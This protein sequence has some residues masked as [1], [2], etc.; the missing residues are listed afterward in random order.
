MAGQLELARKAFEERSWR[1]AFSQLAAACTEEALGL[2]D[3][4]LLAQ[5]AYLCGEDAASEKAW[6]EANQRSAEKADWARAARCAFWLGVTLQAR[7]ERSQAG[8]WFA[9]AQRVL[10]DNDHDCVERG[11]LLVGAGLKLHHERNYDASTQA[12]EQALETGKHFND[13]DL[14]ATARQGLGRILIKQ[15]RISKGSPMLDESMVAVLANE[16]SPIP[17][18]II[19]CSVIEACQEILDIARA[20]EWTAALSDWLDAQ[21]DLVPYRG[22]CQI[23]RSEIMTLEGR[24]ADATEEIAEA[25]ERLV[26]PPQPQLGMALNQQAEVHR[27]RGE[28]DAAE[29]A[30][31]Q[32]NEKAFVL[33][34]G[35][36][37]LKLAKGETE[38]AVAAIQ[39]SY[40]ATSKEVTRCRVLPAYVEI[41]LAAG[42]IEAAKAGQEELAEIA[43]TLDSPFLRGVALRCKGV[44]LLAQGN[45]ADALATF[46]KVWEHWSALEV[47]YE[48]AR[49]R[50]LNAQAS[51]QAGDEHTANSELDAARHVFEQLGA[52]HDLKMLEALSGSTPAQTPGGL[53]PREVQI[54]SL[55]AKGRSN[56]EIASELVISERT[57]A[58]HMSNIFN[59]LDVTSRTAASAF[60]FENNLV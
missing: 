24:W 9:R 26:K 32:A 53:S 40:E 12:W 16:V 30:Y 59:K 25:C 5:T 38:A 19:Y 2:D 58:R 11:W 31:R 41:K 43:E 45:A 23:H 27:L 29:E 28:F 35:W 22:R 8:G 18:G 60:A 15:G 57:V 36:A 6:I 51:K 4:E 3:L 42:N 20:Q 34:P 52:A 33:Q 13:V 10:E 47:P 37:L 56:R 17:A 50:L 54:L 14:V 55:V 7:S 21:P 1:V 48:S 46:A 49:L 44:V 39:R